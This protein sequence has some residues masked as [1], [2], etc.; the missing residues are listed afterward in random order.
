MKDNQSNGKS[1]YFLFFSYSQKKNNERKSTIFFPLCH[2]FL[3][4]QYIDY[5]FIITEDLSEL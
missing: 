3:A 5:P 4:Y 2:L 1:L